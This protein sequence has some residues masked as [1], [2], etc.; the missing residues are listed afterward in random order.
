MQLRSQYL[1]DEPVKARMKSVV[2]QVDPTHAPGLPVL[3]PVSSFTVLANMPPPEAGGTKNSKRKQKKRSKNGSTNGNKGSSHQ[4][5]KKNASQN[6][7]NKEGSNNKK[8]ETRQPKP[9][10]SAASFPALSDSNR[11]V[12]V[13][14]DG[15]DS[16]PNAVASDTCSTVTTLSSSSC[17]GKQQ[18][19]GYAAA[20]RKAKPAESVS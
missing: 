7:G 12:E 14:V 3:G 20:L 1:G 9:D 15:I 16:A 17:S 2:R 10:L 8:A 6:K 11:K 5:G 4:G 13:V 18:L 19:G